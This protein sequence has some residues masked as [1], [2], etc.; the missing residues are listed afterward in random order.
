MSHTFQVAPHTVQVTLFAHAL[1]LTGNL[2]ATPYGS[3]CP[4]IAMMCAIWHA[5]QSSA[6]H[7]I[8]RNVGMQTACTMLDRQ[9]TLPVVI[10]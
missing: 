8:V 10:R 4:F 1:A 3:L 2:L 5:V 6:T 9:S 7:S